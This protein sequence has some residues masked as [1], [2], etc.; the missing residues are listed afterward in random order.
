MDASAIFQTLLRE[1]RLCVVATASKD[2]KPE[3][4][5]IEF[6]HDGQHN[7][8]FET[9]PQYRKYPNLKSN[10]RASVVITQEPHTV[11]MDV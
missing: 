10:P 4:A 2:G 1:N 3:A 6:A 11:Q 7:L 9:F 8:F 5:T